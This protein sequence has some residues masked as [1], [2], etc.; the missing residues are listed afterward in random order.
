[1]LVDGARLQRREDVAGQKFFPQIFDDDLAGASL[2]RFLNDGL[3][4]VALSNVANHRDDVVRIVFL[5]PWN[6]DRSIESTGIR[7]HNFLRHERS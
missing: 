1:M 2:V 4:I 3:N 7:K 5:Q 6:D